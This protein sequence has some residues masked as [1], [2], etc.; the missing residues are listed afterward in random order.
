VN[1]R[2]EE[3]RGQ[4]ILKF[5]GGSLGLDSILLMKDSVVPPSY[6]TSTLL[7]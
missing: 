6:E 3:G 4:R 2:E 7:L 5:V 1:P